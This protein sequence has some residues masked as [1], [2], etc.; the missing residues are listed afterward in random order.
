MCEEVRTIFLQEI[1]KESQNVVLGPFWHF[2]KCY[3]G[4]AEQVFNFSKSRFTKSHFVTI[5][6]HFLVS[7]EQALN[8]VMI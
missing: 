6:S 3:F 5:K 1:E 4:F 7:A 8:C 2:E